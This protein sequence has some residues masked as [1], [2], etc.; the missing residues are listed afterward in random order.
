MF[1]HFFPELVHHSGT[2]AYWY[3]ILDTGIINTNWL[4][5]SGDDETLF[6][7][8]WIEDDSH[9]ETDDGI[10]DFVRSAGVANTLLTMSIF[11]QISRLSCL[12]QLF[13]VCIKNS[14]SPPRARPPSPRA[15]GT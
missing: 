4:K 11:F 12:W 1:I 14:L 2:G 6:F 3:I 8:T 5:R 13:W 9:S 10:P 15:F 7:L